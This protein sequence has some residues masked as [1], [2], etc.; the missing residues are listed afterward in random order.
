MLPCSL[1]AARFPPPKLYNYVF[2][3]GM[4]RKYIVSFC[5]ELEGIYNCELLQRKFLSD[6]LGCDSLI[7]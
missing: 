6:L 3:N 1:C 7:K 4:D 2:V 5:K